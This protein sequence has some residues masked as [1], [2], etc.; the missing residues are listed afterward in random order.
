MDTLRYCLRKLIYSLPL[1]FGVTL[2]SFVLMVYFGPDKTYDLLGRN[3]T[4]EEIN[5]IRHEL[6]YDQPFWIRYLHYL[7]QV[8][9]FDFGYSDSSG[10]SVTTILERTIPISLLLALPGFILGHLISIGLGL[11]A[12]HHRGRWI[13]KL[14]MSSSVI[15]MSISYLIIII[16]LQLIFC[17]SYGLNLFP[18]YGWEV[19]SLSSYLYYVTVPTLCSIF[20]SV[21]Y[22]TR[23]YRALFV[24]EMTRDHIRTVRAFGHSHL[25]VLFKHVLKNALIPILTRI[26]FSIPFVMIGGSL[27]LESYFGIPGVGLITYNAI[28][29]GDLPVLKAVI[30]LLTLVF[31]VIVSTVDILYKLVDPR[32]SLK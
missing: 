7:Q 26:V 11:F 21:G 5:A 25:Q 19:N 1:L 32:I 31:I 18:V 8:V 13:D 20:V 23:F 30:V 28:T 3:P 14:V 6:G 17:S 29:T 10:E 16:V 4:V 9:T 2:I 24:E 12:S 22:S 15:G 27:L